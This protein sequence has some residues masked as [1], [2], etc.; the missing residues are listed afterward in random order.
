RSP[1]L[2]RET[3]AARTQQ[4]IAQLRHAERREGFAGERD[5]LRLRAALAEVGRHI[6]PPDAPVGRADDEHYRVGLREPVLDVARVL[7]R[8]DLGVVAATPP[9]IRV[10]R[11]ELD[12]HALTAGLS[13][14]VLELD[15]AVDAPVG[16]RHRPIDLTG[17]GGD[18]D[19]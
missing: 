12:V 14:F 2:R 3:S 16:P 8:E 10:A 9:Q 6:H 4:A 18:R 5:L 7:D 17:L 1:N 19:G 15:L 11:L 13:A